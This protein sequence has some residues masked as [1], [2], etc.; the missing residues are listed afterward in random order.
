MQIG[1][2]T[3]GPRGRSATKLAYEHLGLEMEKWENY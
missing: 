1:Y 3:R 2:L